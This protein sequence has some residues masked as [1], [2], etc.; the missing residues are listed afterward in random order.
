MRYNRVENHRSQGQIGDS[1]CVRKRVWDGESDG[2]IR[3]M[4]DLYGELG[5]L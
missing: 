3:G 5:L 4:G 2:G 1:E